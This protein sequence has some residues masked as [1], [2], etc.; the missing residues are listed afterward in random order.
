MFKM[1]VSLSVVL[2]SLSA[3]AWGPPHRYF[4]E[5]AIDS[6][7]QW[8]Q[9]IVAAETDDFIKT[10]CI[11]PDLVRKPA[12]KPLWSP[13]LM[14]DVYLHYAISTEHNYRVYE[15]YFNIV[16]KQF[17]AGEIQE[18]MRHAGA[19]SHFLQDSTCPCHFRYAAQT[20]FYD[21]KFKTPSFVG[22]NPF[23][24][25]MFVPEKY[26]YISLH[27]VVDSGGFD[28]EQLRQA[29]GAYKPRLLGKTIAEAIFNLD[30][31]HESYMEESAKCMIPMLTAYCADDLEG[32]G[33]YG[34][35]AGI[36]SARLTAD[37][38]YTVLCISSD[39]FEESDLA[40]LKNKVS[41]ADVPI[42]AANTVLPK[43]K[44][45]IPVKLKTPVDSI[46]EFE[47]GFVVNDNVEYSFIVPSGLFKTLEVIVGQQP[48]CGVKGSCSFEILLDGESASKT[49]KLSAD[50]DP[51]MLKV[52]L[53]NAK[54]ITL[55]TSDS[56]K[57]E[58]IH[59]V[60]AEPVLKR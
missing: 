4:S 10:Y 2:M 36:L 5:V 45:P 43:Y 41:L 38:L 52:N 9:D 3:A 29:Y 34:L 56:K 51:Q 40:K 37:Y 26:Q 57:A 44:E 54:Q 8:Q 25:L 58:N 6:L 28:L 31:E 47:K 18:A 30:L 7:P 60:W 12:L 19:F 16:S 33:R 11:I 22:S 20:R 21:E 32:Y 59:A 42:A 55:K 39:R 14:D 23:K 35:R 24:D 15:H 48:E 53:Q 13:Y 1:S 50:D 46:E 17:A 49:Q 27:K